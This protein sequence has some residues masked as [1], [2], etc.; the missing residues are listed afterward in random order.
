MCV[1]HFNE[2]SNI[3]EKIIKNAVGISLFKKSFQENKWVL[4]NCTKSY[5]YEGSCDAFKT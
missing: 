2:K 4:F 1:F 3:Y 5:I